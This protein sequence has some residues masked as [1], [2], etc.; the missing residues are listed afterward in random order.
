MAPALAGGL[1]LGLLWLERARPLRPRREPTGRRLARNCAVGVLTGV[2]V[3]LVERPVVQAVATVIERRGWGLLPRLALPRR[4]RLP[5][6]IVLMDYT[7]YWWHVLLHRVPLLW[8]CHRAHHADLDLDTSTALRF[9]AAEF[10]LSVPWRVAQVAL[11]GIS[12]KGLSIW[13][14][15]TAAEVMF[16]HS[17]VRLPL[18]FER[19][20]CRFVITP[21]LHGIHHS[22][23]HREQDSHF[24]SGLTLWDFLHGTARINKLRRTVTIGLREY[25]TPEQV[26]L[27]RTLA[28]PFADPPDDAGGGHEHRR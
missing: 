14:A 22:I 21:R 25:R 18:A 19:R 12:R 5:L 1:L 27:S 16:H 9:H 10:L 13:G 4:L 2:T 17:N 23:V 3:L 6:M 26:T 11:L 20:L 28:M 15:L 24:S 8:R 7:L